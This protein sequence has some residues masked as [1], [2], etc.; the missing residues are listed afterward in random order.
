[1]LLTDS[2]PDT[3][4]KCRYTLEWIQPHHRADWVGIH[5]AR[6]NDI[7]HGIL[8][9]GLV[10]DLAPYAENIRREVKISPTSRVDFEL[11]TTTTT[12]TTNAGTTT[13]TTA[14]IGAT[15]DKEDL[16][17]DVFF[18]V[19]HEERGGGWRTCAEGHY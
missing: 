19:S 9:R 3:K 4:R 15:K 2:G 5:S 10:P 11:T 6:A 16:P 13:T 18:S 7:V 8:S 14:P 1:M 12:T 17:P